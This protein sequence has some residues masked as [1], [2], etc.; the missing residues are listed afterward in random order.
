[1]KSPLQ[2]QI[3]ALAYDDYVGR[4]GIG[5]V[6]KGTVK[7]GETV[8]I[9]KADGSVARGRITKLTVYEGLKQVEKSE[10]Y[11]G[12]IVV[13]AGMADI[14]IG[15]TICNADNPLP[16][17]MIHIEEPTLSMN[18][19]VNDSPFAGRVVNSLQLDT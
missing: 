16:M 11:A 14:S 3:S 9:C 6:Y 2:L 15:E 7:N 8:S 17:E 4:L 10:A 1:M 13:V 19:L 18:F 12:D 5:R